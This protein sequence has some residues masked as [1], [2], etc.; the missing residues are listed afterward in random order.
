MSVWRRANSSPCYIRSVSFIPRASLP[1]APSSHTSTLQGSSAHHYILAAV[2]TRS[3]LLVE[4]W[5]IIFTWQRKFSHDPNAAFHHTWDSHCKE[6]E[7]KSMSTCLTE[8]WS[9]EPTQML[10]TEKELPLLWSS[11]LLSENRRKKT[12]KMSAWI[13]QKEKGNIWCL[14]VRN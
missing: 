1:R 13:K 2:G 14:W 11:V 7:S 9:Q 10:F 4:K 3:W 12:G 5:L 8:E 6:P